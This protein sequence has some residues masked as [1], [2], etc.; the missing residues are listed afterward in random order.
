MLLV[1]AIGAFVPFSLPVPADHDASP[2]LQTLDVCS[3]GV[4]ALST[5]GEM[6]CISLYKYNPL[7]PMSG[8][9]ERPVPE[10][11]TELILSS[12]NERPPRA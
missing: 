10:A 3:S 6:P 11:L 12:R 1:F 5:N 2:M 9:S 7:P 8:Q 4:P